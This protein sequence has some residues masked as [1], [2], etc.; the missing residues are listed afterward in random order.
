MA[1]MKALVPMIFWT[2]LVVFLMN[3]IGFN[4]NFREPLWAIGGALILLLIILV[5]VWLY[6]VIAKDEPW[7]WMKQ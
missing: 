1:S 4:E 7:K 5:N 6:F 3:S 2:A